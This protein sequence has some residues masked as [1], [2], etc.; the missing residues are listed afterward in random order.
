[1]P[2][3]ATTFA[4]ARAE[5]F[6]A[7]QLNTSHWAEMVTYYPRAGGTPSSIPVIV[8]TSRQARQDDTNVYDVEVAVVTIAIDP[9]G[10][11]G[12]ASEPKR[13]DAIHRDQYGDPPNKGWSY[14]GRMLRSTDH[15]WTLEFER[16]DL[17]QSGA[18]R[19]I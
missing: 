4:A 18:I 1:M 8:G 16:V 2:N 14:S 12:L 9:T 15:T 10:V 11:Q 5:N 19:G 7:V 17:V 3:Q 6:L 13:G